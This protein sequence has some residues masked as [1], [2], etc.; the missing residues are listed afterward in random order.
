VLLE[1]VVW[2]GGS[3]G[4]AVVRGCWADGGP[5]ELGNLVLLCG[6]HHRLIHHSDWHRGVVNGRAEFYP[7]RYIDAQQRPRRNTLHLRN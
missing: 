3:C 1:L 6:R 2:V 4:S 7:P 5:T